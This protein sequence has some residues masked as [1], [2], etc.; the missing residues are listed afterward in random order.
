MNYSSAFQIILKVTERNDLHKHI[1]NKLA[2]QF[3]VNEN[4]KEKIRQ[5]MRKFYSDIR[6]PHT[7][8]GETDYSKITEAGLRQI[9]IAGILFEL[10]INMQYQIDP[11]SK[12]IFN[13]TAIELFQSQKILEDTLTLL[14]K[15]KAKDYFYNCN[16]DE[17]KDIA[18]S[19]LY[20]HEYCR[21]DFVAIENKKKLFDSLKTIGYI[22]EQYCKTYDDSNEKPQLNSIQTI[23]EYIKSTKSFEDGFD[24]LPTHFMEESDK[25]K[26]IYLRNDVSLGF[27][28]DIYDKLRSMY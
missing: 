12:H 6:S 18:N 9:D 7:H 20:F 27:L 28:L 22:L 17:F 26:E 4:T 21:L 15:N 8:A 19:L 24:D 25:L 2:D 11:F 10:L 1:A 13:S 16:K 23:C 5:W 3:D 14:T